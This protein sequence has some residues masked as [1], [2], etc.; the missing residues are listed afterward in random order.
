MTL[1]GG[2]YEKAEPC[3]RTAIAVTVI[4]AAL[5][6]GFLIGRR[7][8]GSAPVI[9]ERDASRPAVTDTAVRSS[10]S[11][12]DA[13][14]ENVPLVIL[15]ES[16]AENSSSPEAA[17]YPIDL[18][19]AGAEELALLPGIGEVLAQRIVEYRQEHGPFAAPESL[20]M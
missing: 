10:G 9:V 4:F 7:S 12:D 13:A 1:A 3:G 18:N 5:L 20:C 19:T 11:N 15:P 17:L 16:G 8:M 14:D 6:A 2:R